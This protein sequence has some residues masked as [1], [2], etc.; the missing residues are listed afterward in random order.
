MWLAWS[1]CSHTLTFAFLYFSLQL[2]LIEL[3]EGNKAQC[4]LLAEITCIFFLA[5]LDALGILHLCFSSWPL[6]L[7]EQESSVEMVWGYLLASL[8]LPSRSR[9]ESR[10]FKENENNQVVA[11]T[12][13]RSKKLK[14][15]KEEKTS[16]IVC[17]WDGN[18]ISHER[19]R[20]RF[21]CQG[22]E[23]IKIRGTPGKAVAWELS[24]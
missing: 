24:C 18:Q 1:A 7:R 12:V 8:L 17:W 5:L 16:F 4:C 15:Q 6:P 23:I 20:E 3:G 10:L 19:H 21:V 11:Y 2:Y 13:S 9:V 22:T 14:K